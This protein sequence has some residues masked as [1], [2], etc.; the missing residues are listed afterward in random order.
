MYGYVYKV[1]N[2]LNGKMYVG[3][4]KGDKFDPK[5][6]GSGKILHQAYEK[7]GFDNFSVEV[8]EWCRTHSE[9]D[10]A[11]KKWIKFFNATVEG[12]NI[13]FGGEGGGHPVTT[14]TRKKISKSLEGRVV[15]KET[16]RRLS[17]SHR[18]YRPT[19]EARLHQ[20]QAQMGRKLSPS[21]VAKIVARQTGVPKSDELKKKI[22]DS[23]KGRRCSRG[24]KG[25]I[26]VNDGVVATLI[27]PDMLPEY[28]SKGYRRGR[29]PSFSEKMRH[30]KM[31]E[32]NKQKLLAVN[33]GRKLSE[34]TRRKISKKLK[35]RKMSSEEKKMRSKAMKLMWERRRNR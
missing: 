28:I 12:Y 35:G 8:L 5:Y 4:H 16:R 32:E 21:H 19:A 3:Q 22:S 27:H 31:S 30:H 6:K 33:A 14:E 2:N 18:G 15:S 13:A 9:L 29:L 20:S 26:Q 24:T 10:E 23:L 11:E 25:L 1:T 34:E 7:Y 17:E